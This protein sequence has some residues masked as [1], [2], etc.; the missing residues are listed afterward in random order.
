MKGSWLTA[1]ALLPLGS[2]I[3]SSVVAPQ[4]RGREVGRE[5]QVWSQASAQ[6]LSGVYVSTRL[7][8]SLANS[9]RKIIY[10]FQEDGHY[11]G[12]ALVET[13][14][15][16]FEVITGEWR[17]Q[18][19]QISLDGADPAQLEVAADRSL[20]IT[21]ESGQVVLRRELNQ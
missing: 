21:G 15:P 11:T 5:D 6:S 18:G 10:L 19:S 17:M 3:A 16:H 2:C 1:L 20:R 14:P 9:V 13:S 7:S 4:D 12:A 8:G